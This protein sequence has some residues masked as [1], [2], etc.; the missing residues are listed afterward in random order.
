MTDFEWPAILQRY[1]TEIRE[2][3]QGRAFWDQSREKGH[4]WVATHF[5][6]GGIRTR[7]KIETLTIEPPEGG[8]Y[9]IAVR[10]KLGGSGYDNG[11]F[12]GYKVSEGGW[13][14]GSNPGG[15]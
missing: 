13:L 5:T 10:F 15:H 8:Q 2:F 12:S 7:Q 4:T 3:F 9:E 1:E 14:V 6:P 11:L